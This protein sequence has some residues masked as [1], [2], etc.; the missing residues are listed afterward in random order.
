MK[1]IFSIFLTGN[2]VSKIGTSTAIHNGQQD[3][4]ENIPPQAT[5]QKV[6]S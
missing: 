5:K 2:R 3:Q 6:N 4:S 1:I